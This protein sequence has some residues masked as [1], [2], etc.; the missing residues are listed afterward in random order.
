MNLSP[1]EEE[2]VKHEVDIM[3]LMNHS[4]I[5]KLNETFENRTH[6]YMVTELVTDG[7]LFDY[8]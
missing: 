8:V 4:C 7:D 2:T 5:I 3:K 1:N 6:I